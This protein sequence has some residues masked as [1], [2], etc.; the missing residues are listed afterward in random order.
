[1]RDRRGLSLAETVTG[2]SLGDGDAAVE[3]LALDVLRAWVAAARGGN[4]R[5]NFV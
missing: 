1:M 2:D 5:N 3:T 4:T